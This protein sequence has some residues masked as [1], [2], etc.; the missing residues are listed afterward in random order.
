MVSEMPVKQ[1]RKWK[2]EVVEYENRQGVVGGRPNGDFYPKS[3][4]QSELQSLLYR[5]VDDVRGVTAGRLRL[6][7]EK[8]KPQ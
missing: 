8:G 1:Q 7:L 4:L 5:A 6:K 3:E 2:L